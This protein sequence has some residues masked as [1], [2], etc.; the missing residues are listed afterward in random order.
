MEKVNEFEE[1]IETQESESA[2]ANI[3]NSSLT[4]SDKQK[5]SFRG[6]AKRF[7]KAF[8]ANLNKTSLDLSDEDPVIAPDVWLEFL[9]H[10]DIKMYL[11]SFRN[12]E[13]AKNVD[14]Q[15]REGNS[16]TGYVKM[17]EM[18]KRDMQVDNSSVMVV[19]LPEKED[20]TYVEQIV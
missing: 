2:L 20:R 9:N 16:I 12:E 18:L 5:N 7:T 10:P 19:R 3:V 11:N 4:M 14:T 15:I 17:K 1:L 8:K 6:L 13:F